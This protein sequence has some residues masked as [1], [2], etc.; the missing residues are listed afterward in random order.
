MVILTN[1]AAQAFLNNR[2]IWSS[3]CEQTPEKN[4]IA[5]NIC[6]ATGDKRKSNN[7]S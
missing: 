1:W 5:G 7:L 3:D 6:I 4:Y 2:A